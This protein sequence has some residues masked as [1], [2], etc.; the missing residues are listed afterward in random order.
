MVVNDIDLQ[1]LLHS[2]A[3]NVY[4]MMVPE[5]DDEPRYKTITTINEMAV[6]PY[7]LNFRIT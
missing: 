5:W 1:E 6:A 3:M 4:R 2:F 7:G